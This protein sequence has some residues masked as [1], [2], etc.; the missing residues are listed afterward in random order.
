MNDFDQPICPIVL[1]AKRM[2]LAESAGTGEV[3][4]HSVPVTNGS[5]FSPPGPPDLSSVPN[6]YH[7]LSQ[8]FSKE[9]ALSLPP[10]RPY[11]CAIDLL[12]GAPLPTSRLYKL[13][14]PERETMERY[15]KDSLAAGL[16]RPSSSPVGAGFFFVEKKDTTLRPCIDYRGLNE[17]TIKNKYPLPLIDS[18][19]EPLHQATIFTKLD[20][21]SDYHLVRIRQG[22]EWKTAF[23]TPLGHF[24]YLVMPFGL[25]NAPAVF[26][27]LVNDVL[28]DML[29]K[30]VFV[31]IDDILIFSK[32]IQEHVNHVRGNLSQ[33]Q[34][35]SKLLLIGRDLLLAN[36]SSDPSRQFIVEVDASDSGV[37][38]VLSQRCPKDQKVHPCAFF[39][40]RLTPA[41][42]N[43]DIGNRELLAVVLALQEW[44]H[45]LEGA[46]LPF[47]VWTDHKNLSYLRSAKRLNSRQAR[48][49]LFLGRFNFVLTYRPG[50]Q[51]VKP[52]AL[53]RQS[54]TEEF[55]SQPGPIIPPS[56]LVDSPDS[57]E[58]SS[59]STFLLGAVGWEIERVVQEAQR[60][61]PDP[62]NG[63]PGCLFVPDSVRSKVL[64]W[65]HNSKLTCHPG[66]NR[67][68][69]FL[70]QRFWWPSMSQDTRSFV[71]ACSVCA[72]SKSSH[73]P[74][75]G[76][77]HPLPIPSRPWSHIAVDF[78]TGLP[79]SEGNN[80]ILTIVDRFSKAVH[81]VPLPK[82]PSSS[83]TAKLLV[84]HVFR[85]HGIPT[86]IVSD[87]GPQF[88]S[89][90]WKAFCQSLG[91]TVSLTSGYHP[92]SNGQTE[93]ANQD[94]ESAL[95]C[96]TA[97]NP[98]TWSSFL[99]WVEY[100][101]NSLVS[102]ATGMSPFMV[103]LGFQPPLFPAQEIE[104]AVPS[105]QAHLRRCRNIWRVAK[106]ALR[107]TSLR[108]QQ[109]ANR[110]RVPSPTYQPGQR[111]WL[112]S[113]D[114][115]LQV[116]SRKLAPKYVGPFTIEKIINPAVVRLKLPSPP[117]DPPPP[118]RIIDDHPAFT[119]RRILDVRRRGEVTSILWTGR[120]GLTRRAMRTC[121]V[122]LLLL[123]APSLLLGQS[124]QDFR[125]KHVNQ[126]MSRNDCDTVIRNRRI[127]EPDGTCKII[128]TFI[129]AGINQI[130]QAEEWHL[131]NCRYAGTAETLYITI[132]CRNG[133]P[134]H[135]ESG[136]RY[137]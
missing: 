134:V 79:I 49:A 72:R 105:V 55:D 41:E 81:F 133:Y 84:Q 10:H 94:L 115:P 103:S 116:E 14:R 7:D 86:D 44:R 30:F 24:E 87:R 47:I 23:N 107:R 119:V 110:H 40:R 32:D 114:L 83:D 99:P 128:D 8:V 11:D 13:T 18:A 137:I 76:L 35:K 126:Y 5:K 112:S 1:S 101:H 89:Q 67:T 27:A 135:F 75:A 88:S 69:A 12:P 53:S 111:V 61:Q 56:C 100:A 106:A 52:D 108:N 131:P 2:D 46:E 95:R 124:Y 39:S 109:I 132:A 78:V 4:V 50:S 136:S 74:P 77:L 45:W 93:R 25:T 64:Q 97:R 3:L 92:Q 59:T 20:L 80:T 127:T 70:R 58:R 91:S 16:I 71:S 22:D 129:N 37:G 85:L 19:F 9:L 38:A 65:G 34:P 123:L 48:W 36:N 43:Y 117:A 96:I 6:V 26:Q 68:L 21:R 82:L 120:L 113:R 62:G 42:T 29:N 66:F 54:T 102:S 31:Y 125:N 57:T 17:I 51:N 118:T 63:P 122:F 73:L 90:V 104:V 28:R 98:T 121:S 60:T 130:N 33:I 15:I